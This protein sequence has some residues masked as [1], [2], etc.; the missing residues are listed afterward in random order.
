MH[1]HGNGVWRWK[2]LKEK[3]LCDLISLV[4]ACPS[5]VSAS[6]AWFREPG[7]AQGDAARSVHRIGELQSVAIDDD[8]PLC[9]QQL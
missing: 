9:L 6:T 4:D 2:P 8:Q 7:L 1:F 5:P 3:K